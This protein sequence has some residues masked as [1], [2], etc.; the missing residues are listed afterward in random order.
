MNFFKSAEGKW[1]L[2][3]LAI[4][5]LLIV[6][7]FGLFFSRSSCIPS[8]VPS[9]DNIFHPGQGAVTAG[10]GRIDVNRDSI[11]YVPP[12]TKENP[13]PRPVR[14]DKAPDDKVIIEPVKNSDLPSLPLISD[15]AND[16]FNV[17]TEKGFATIKIQR[18][19]FIFEPTIGAIYQIG[20]KIEP[21]LGCRLVKY[22]RLGLG[23]IVTPESFGV[24][25]DW[26]IGNL[27][28]GIGAVAEFASPT[29]PGAFISL[30]V[31]PLN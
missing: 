12:P 14:I 10:P 28:A 9:L 5:C 30:N 8:F 25:L 15:G 19:A 21:S 31:I 20:K 29:S 6:L 27:T 4:A 26:R 16:V 11:S 24:Q 7:A 3:R 1:N 22:S 2:K 18:F 17:P 13:K 23:P